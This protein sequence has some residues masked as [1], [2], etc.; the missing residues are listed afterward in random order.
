[1]SFNTPETKPP[2]KETGF[3]ANSLNIGVSSVMNIS[4]LLL[5]KKILILK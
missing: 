3:W 4:N 2:I 5:L 1:M